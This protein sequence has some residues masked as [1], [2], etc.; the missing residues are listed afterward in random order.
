[1]WILIKMVNAVSVEERTAPL[2]TV[3]FVALL[4]KKL[5]QIGSVLPCHSRD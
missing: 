5:R 3:D 1:M 4:E 2:Y